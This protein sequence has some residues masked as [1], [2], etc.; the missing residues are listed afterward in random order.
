MKWR[1][2][3]VLILLF[4]VWHAWQGRALQRPP[5]V[6]VDAMP[7]QA[8]LPAGT[9]IIERAGYQLTPLQ[10]FAMEARVLSAER[11]RFDRQADLSPIDLALG[12]GPM[13]DSTILSDIEISQSA[14]FY[15]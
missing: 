10:A 5:G 2:V 1:W 15:F 4:G 8:E 7:L 6:L 3:F 14:R 13:S 9:P 12:W 11:Y